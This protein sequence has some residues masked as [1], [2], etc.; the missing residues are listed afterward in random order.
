VF[1]AGDDGGNLWYTTNAGSTWSNKSFY[2]SGSGSVN[3]IAFSNNSIAYMAHDTSG[4]VGRLLRSYDGGYS[5][6][7][8]P[9]DSSDMLS[10]TG[11]AALAGCKHDPN[12]VV[13]GGTATNGIDG[14]V[15][16]CRAPGSMG[17][18]LFERPVSPLLDELIAYYKMEEASGS[19]VDSS[20]N[21]HTL[22][23][24]NT[25][26]QAFGHRGNSA[27]FT[28]S[29][30]ETLG[31]IVHDDFQMTKSMTFA[32]WILNDDSIPINNRLLAKGEADGNPI[33]YQLVIVTSDE[34]GFYVYESDGSP[35]NVVTTTFGG[36]DIGKW[37]FVACRYDSVND[38]IEIRV[39]D[40]AWVT[41]PVTVTIS[42]TSGPFYVGSIEGVAHWD[43]RIDE[44]GIWG[45]YLSDDEVDD[46]WNDGL[47]TTHPFV[48]D[49]PLPYV[50]T[51]LAA[52]ENTANYDMAE[53]FG[54]DSNGHLYIFGRRA[55]GHIG[56][57][58]K[59]R[60]WKSTD[61]GATWVQSDIYSDAYDDRN[62]AGGVVPATDTL[63][64]FLRRYS[65]PSGP[66]IDIRY[67]RSTN[68]GDSWSNLGTIGVGSLDW[69]APFGPIIEL[70]SGKLMQ[71][72][73][74][75]DDPITFYR[76]WVQF[77]S[78][79]GQTWGSEV[80]VVSSATENQE[81]YPVYIDGDTDG[82]SRLIMFTRGAGT[83]F[84]S[85]DG[86]ATWTDAGE[87][88]ATATGYDD[89]DS[90]S[91]AKVGNYLVFMNC[92]RQAVP[93]MEVRY[94]VG[95]ADETFNEPIN[96]TSFTSIYESS[97]TTV[98]HFGQAQLLYFNGK[99]YG[100]FYDAS[101]YVTKDRPDLFVSPF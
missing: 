56:S 60:M 86:G 21:G 62:I 5:W 2:D 10:Q 67:F 41:E 55:T 89:D 36:I 51:P 80:E 77:S 22:P 70:P 101:E 46:L 35:S 1:W 33:E 45:R 39:D 68:G 58:G 73:Y 85:D 98:A 30:S 74:G 24:V 9:E 25:V 17:D 84:T 37:H 72:F 82:T 71:A 63:I 15:A 88:D 83:V 94:S 75:G 4:S 49:G 18:V 6:V 42:G 100:L 31:P 34:V 44:V 23:D 8:M 66:S 97:V 50:R 59:A 76:I 52:I 95:L 7:V 54:S 14:I 78:N 81:P 38:Q 47:G 16:R 43:G 20:G 32:F 27:Q 26:T 69:Y 53:A 19:R 99:L 96:W 11:I 79:D 48:S 92:H 28:K 13:F 90:P 65:A 61:N 91:C 87:I 40:E 12:F 64:V 29:S 93:N 57:D 3:D